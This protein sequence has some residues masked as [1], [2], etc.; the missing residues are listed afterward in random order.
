[1]PPTSA[2]GPELCSRRYICRHFRHLPWSEWSSELTELVHPYWLRRKRPNQ[3]VAIGLRSTSRFEEGEIRPKRRR[4][5][6]G[7]VLPWQRVS[8][9]R[10]SAP[11]AS[12]GPSAR[13][14]SNEV[15]FR[16]R[17]LSSGIRID[18]CRDRKWLDGFSS[19]KR[20]FPEDV[21]PWK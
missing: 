18:R 9:A 13:R 3:S 11:T 8:P 7:V 10:W 6:W 16:F 20:R 14:T 5:G 21:Q 15:H 12:A 19:H 4:S 1:M 2:F 17:P